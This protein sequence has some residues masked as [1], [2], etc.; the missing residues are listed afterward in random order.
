MGKKV[1]KLLLALAL[2]LIPFS[3]V[4]GELSLNFTAEEVNAVA[5][6]TVQD[7]KKRIDQGERVA[8][9][10]SRTGSSWSHSKVK[11]IGAIRILMNDVEKLAASAIPLGHKVVIYCT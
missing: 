8:V 4:A 1:L 7:L 3:A 9:I 5:K 10:D 11:I 2:A 6:M